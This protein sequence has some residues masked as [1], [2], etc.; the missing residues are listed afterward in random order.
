MVSYEFALGFIVVGILP[1]ACALLGIVAFLLI[2]A[3]RRE[4]LTA[5][6]E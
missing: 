6:R 5:M 2:P 4:V 3:V 1:A